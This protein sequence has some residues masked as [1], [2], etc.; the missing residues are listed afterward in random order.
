MP[1]YLSSSTIA[2]TYA[3]VRH[4]ARWIHQHVIPFPFACPTDGVKAPEAEDTQW[5]SPTTGATG[6]IWSSVQPDSQ[7]LADAFGVLD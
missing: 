4:F 7:S 1:K 3:T 5:R 2:R 6:Y